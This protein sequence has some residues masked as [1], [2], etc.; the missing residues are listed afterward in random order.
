MEEAYEEAIKEELR[1][2]V[3]LSIKDSRNFTFPTQK[4]SRFTPVSQSS[5]I[6]FQT[7]H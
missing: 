1:R 6:F 2:A 7:I 4:V 3:P 5:T